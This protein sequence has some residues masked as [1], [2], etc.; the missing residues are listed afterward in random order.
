M[1]RSRLRQYV[2]LRLIELNPVLAELEKEGRI[3]ID[4]RKIVT[5]S[6]F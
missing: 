2:G 4:T 3:R 6:S 5:L 1:E